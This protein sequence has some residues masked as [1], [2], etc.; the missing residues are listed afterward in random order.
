MESRLFV[1]LALAIAFFGLSYGLHT[2]LIA[3]LPSPQELQSRAAVPS[4]KIYDRHGRLLYEIIG[5][6]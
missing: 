3:D 4:T 1:L 6:P 2:W 5:A